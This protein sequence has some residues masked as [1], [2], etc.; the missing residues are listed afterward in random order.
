MFFVGLFSSNYDAVGRLEIPG[1]LRDQFPG[2][3]YLTYGFDQNIMLLPPQVFENLSRMIGSLN[4]ADPSARAL[5]RMFLGSACRVDIDAQGDVLI[6]ERL[7]HYAGLNAL[8]FMVGQGEYV[9]VW[10]P[11]QWEAQE[12]TM[13]DA[14]AN[15]ARFAGLDLRLR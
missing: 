8:A 10:S 6:P 12:K 2:E 14:D 3:A 11:K 15:A 5:M 1:V 9:E 13:Q 7:A 4:I